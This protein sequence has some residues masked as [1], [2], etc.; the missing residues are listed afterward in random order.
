M[1]QPCKAILQEMPMLCP[2]TILLLLPWLKQSWEGESE[3]I[4]RPPSDGGQ[5]GSEV[6]GSAAR[7]TDASH[8]FWD[9]HSGKF[10]LQLHAASVL[11][12]CAS[13]TK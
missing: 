8:G 13:S 4:S 1:T 11:S 12:Y 7:S 9:S 6:E 10:L 3:M 2:G 5:P